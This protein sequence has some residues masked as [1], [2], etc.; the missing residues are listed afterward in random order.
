MATSRVRLHG[1]H[2]AIVSGIICLAATAH[3]QVRPDSLAPVAALADGGVDDPLATAPPVPREFRGVWVTSVANM[4]WPS[5]PGLPV[6]QQKSELLRSEER[7]VG[8]E[9]RSRW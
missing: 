5:R 9:G 1:F 7:R 3:G 4:D 8:K 6:A 2:Y